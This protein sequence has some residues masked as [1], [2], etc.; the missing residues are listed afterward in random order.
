MSGFRQSISLLV[1]PT[2]FNVEVRAILLD[3]E[4]TTT[5]IQFVRN[6]LFPYAREHIEDF[7]NRRWDEEAVA[8][9]IRSLQSQYLGAEGAESAPIWKNSSLA[10]ERESSLAYIR[11]LMDADDKCTPLKSLQGKVWQEGYETGELRAEVF[12][13][14]PPA[15]C[16]WSSKNKIIAIFSSGSVFAQQL[17]FANTCCGDLSRFLQAFFDTTMGSK[18]NPESYRKISSEIGTPCSSVLFIS[19]AIP[20][21]DAAQA[22]GLET[23]LCLRAA[24]STDPASNHRVIRSFDEVLS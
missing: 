4:G 3:I 7:L 21:L 12:R 14:V 13:D 10:D 16:R 2:P 24:E 9:D 1:P 6:T 8:A 5:P 20:E 18:R 11:S 22:A 17:L 19:D 15:F 23:A